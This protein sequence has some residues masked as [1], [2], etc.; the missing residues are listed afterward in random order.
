MVNYL[1][2]G[3]EI[4]DKRFRKYSEGLPEDLLQLGKDRQGSKGPQRPHE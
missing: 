4:P 3:K 2:Y 1:K